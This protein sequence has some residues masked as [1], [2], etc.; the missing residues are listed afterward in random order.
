MNMNMNINRI[1]AALI[2]AVAWLIGAGIIEHLG[3]GFMILGAAIFFGA[4]INWVV[5]KGF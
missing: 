1:G 5:E 2:G 3:P 4:G